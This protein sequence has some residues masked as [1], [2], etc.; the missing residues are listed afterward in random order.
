MGFNNESY[1]EEKEGSIYRVISY[2][3]CFDEGTKVMLVINDGSNCPY[4]KDIRTG[5]RLYDYWQFMEKI[6]IKNRV[7][8]VILKEGE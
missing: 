7:G 4:F 5:K 6:S 2:M 8:G 3:S 1:S